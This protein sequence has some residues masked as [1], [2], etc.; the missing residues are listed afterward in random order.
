MDKAQRQIYTSVTMPKRRSA[1][2]KYYGESGDYLHDHQS[3]FKSANVNDDIHFLI[4]VLNLKKEDHILDIACG[5]GRHANTLANK[6]YLIDG[7]DFSS[8]LL[9]LAKR[10]AQQLK[11]RMPDYYLAE[12]TKLRLKK[13]YNKAY[14]F[15]SD[16]A[17]IDIPKAMTAISRNMTKGGKVLI[18]SDNIF[19][20]ISCLQ[21]HRKSNLLFDAERLELIDKK[22]NVY[23]PY[24]V[25]PLWRQWMKDTNL[26][27]E[28]I[29][30][31]YKC[32]DYSIHSPRL[33]LLARK[34]A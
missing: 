34:T 1:I 11:G 7:V 20:I 9:N 27:I 3:F 5:Q 31:G 10:E 24:P 23:A 15:F 25:I 16:L 2:Q 8:H 19:R 30:G 12:V 28:R 18:D 14:W 21:K 22:T 17:S 32:Q 13:K 26:S 6:G 29:F 4:K 33:I